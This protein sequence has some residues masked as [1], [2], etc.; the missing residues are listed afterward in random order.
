[1]PPGYARS[2]RA[3]V[4][5]CAGVIVPSQIILVGSSTRSSRKRASGKGR[6]G[7]RDVGSCEFGSQDFGGG[8]AGADAGW[9]WPNVS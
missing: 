7:R 1:M 6:I 4:T 2:V 8:A 9:Y 3:D 5:L